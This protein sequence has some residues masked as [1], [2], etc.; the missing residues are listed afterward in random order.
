MKR[1]FARENRPASDDTSMKH[2]IGMLALLAQERPP[3][4]GVVKP[5]TGA[6]IA[7][8]GTWEFAKEEARR[9]GRPILLMAAAPHCHNIS[10]VW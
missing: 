9:T 2:L 6:R 1:F 5:H 4:P 7:W 10:G 3:E 8:Y